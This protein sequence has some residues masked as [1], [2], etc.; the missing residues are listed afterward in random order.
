VLLC[1]VP[2]AGS[3]PPPPPQG[4]S[5]LTTVSRMRPARGEGMCFYLLAPLDLVPAL[6]ARPYIPPLESIPVRVPLDRMR[7]LTALCLW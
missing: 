6:I 5:P 4:P 3:R 7:A 2:C 1:L